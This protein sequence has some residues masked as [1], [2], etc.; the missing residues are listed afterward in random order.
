MEDN[1]LNWADDIRCDDC[2]Q[3]LLW[4]A[5]APQSFEQVW[6]QRQRNRRR[7]H[8]DSN[9]SAEVAEVENGRA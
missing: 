5:P 6:E 1:E 2:G 9:A 3:R 4:P 8:V 7:K